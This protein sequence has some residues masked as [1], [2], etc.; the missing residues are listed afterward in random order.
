[1]KSMSVSEEILR[2]LPAAQIET[3]PHDLSKPRYLT[4]TSTAQRRKDYQAC[5][6]AS[7]IWN[8]ADT[9]EGRCF[10]LESSKAGGRVFGHPT[11]DVLEL[12]LQGDLNRLPPVEIENVLH[13]LGL[14]DENNEMLSELELEA[15][16]RDGYL[17]LGPLLDDKQIKRMRDRYDAGIEQEGAR[18]KNLE[19]KGIAR[20]IDTVVRPI[21]RDG[22]LDPIFTHPRLLAA[23]RH[24]LGLRF[25]YIGSNYHCALPGYGHQGIHA[26]FMWG[27]KGEPQVV[28]AVWM[29]D[30][31]TEHNGATRVVSGTHLSGVHPTGDTVN[32]KPRDLNARIEGEVRLTG[33]AG[34]CFVYNAH[35]WH[36]GTQNC[37]NKLRRAQHA[38]F[39]R[40]HRPSSTDVFEAIDQEVHKRFGKLE[41]AILDIE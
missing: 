34:C 35:L 15:L 39:S 16:D 37:T 20:L 30:E 14:T 21:N 17:N 23:V 28:N 29:I 11:F 13:R 27:V 10:A 9:D 31:F 12:F 41:R 26:D 7:D 19:K 8:S 24:I 2:Y 3:I 4:V 36:G 6:A 5:V 33:A 32:G 18:P 22:L 25:K 38:F 1:M 40:S